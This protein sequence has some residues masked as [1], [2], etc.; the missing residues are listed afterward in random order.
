MSDDRWLAPITKSKSR[1]KK[2]KEVLSVCP[3]VLSNFDKL[4]NFSY[5]TPEYEFTRDILA[6]TSIH[7]I[8]F[9]HRIL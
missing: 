2:R 8:L 9:H 4:L 1:N 5:T 3:L 7:H 6:D